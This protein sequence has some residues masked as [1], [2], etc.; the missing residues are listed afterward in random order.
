MDLLKLEIEKCED[1]TDLKSIL[2]KINSEI[3][4][5]Q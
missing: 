4:G 3:T 5:V 1:I 2:K